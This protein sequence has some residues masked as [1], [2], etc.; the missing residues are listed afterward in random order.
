VESRYGRN[1]FVRIYLT[2]LVVGGVVWALVNQIEGGH[3][4]S[5][6]YGASGAVAGVV[7]LFALNFPNR[8]ILLFFV[9]PTPAWVVGLLVVGFDLYGAI[10]RPGTNVAYAVHLTGA[11]FA[12]LYFRM[13]WNLGRLVAGR[14]RMPRLWNRPKLRLHDPDGN[15][16]TDLA[17]EVDRIL[18]KIHREGEASLTR[19]E[20]RTLES[21]SRQYQR[22]RRG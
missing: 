12:F 10:V 9:I 1:E 20:R 3:P 7:I 19:K 15:G 14:F 4:L 18:E 2:T 22:R 17:E 5:T 16:A 13:G 11:A 8:T 21:A 6:V